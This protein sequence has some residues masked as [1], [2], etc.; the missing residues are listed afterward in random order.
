M[1]IA[2]VLLPATR[3]QLPASELQMSIE[4]RNAA[5]LTVHSSVKPTEIKEDQ[6]CV[7]LPRL[8][9]DD[10]PEA[11]DGPELVSDYLQSSEDSYGFSLEFYGIDVGS[12]LDAIE[13]VD[14][15][16]LIQFEKEIKDELISKYINF[17]DDEF[18]EKPE[19]EDESSSDLQV[20]EDLSNPSS[21]VIFLSH[22]LNYSFYYGILL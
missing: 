19:G 6:P 15:N 12:E 21:K 8:I 2:L 7:S 13:K 10:S 3:V 4:D 14:T 1:A 9:S 22:F 5:S 17:Q 18:N 11:L 20:L 16:E